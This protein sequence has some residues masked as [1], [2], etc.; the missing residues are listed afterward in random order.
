MPKNTETGT[1]SRDN[2]L[3]SLKDKDCGKEIII[4]IIIIIMIFYAQL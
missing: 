2:M 1:F 3:R 4:I